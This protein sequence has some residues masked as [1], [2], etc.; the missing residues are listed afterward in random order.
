MYNVQYAV[1]YIRI[2]TCTRY[3]YVYNIQHIRKYVIDMLITTVFPYIPWYLL[4]RI[5]FQK[6][7][8]CTVTCSKMSMQVIMYLYQGIKPIEKYDGRI[9]RGLIRQ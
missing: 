4:I 1:Y 3:M 6:Y 7:V 8:M 2:R 9:P 5:N